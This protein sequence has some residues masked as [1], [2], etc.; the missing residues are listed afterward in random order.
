MSE[1]PTLVQVHLPSSVSNYPSWHAYLDALGEDGTWG[2]HLALTAAANVYHMS[3]AIVSLKL[4][5]FS[6]EQNSDFIWGPE[7][8]DTKRRI[9]R[10]VIGYEPSL[11]F[12]ITGI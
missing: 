8:N 1:T 4:S 2:D 10:I 6:T 3:T 5:L 12:N 9:M 11:L 7:Y